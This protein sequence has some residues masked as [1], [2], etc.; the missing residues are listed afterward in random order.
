M[1]SYGLH[2]SLIIQLGAAGGLAG[3]RRLAPGNYSGP[4]GNREATPENP[5]TLQEA[6]PYREAGEGGRSPDPPLVAREQLAPD[7]PAMQQDVTSSAA[8]Q[9]GPAVVVST[10]P[11]FSGPG[12]MNGSVAGRPGP[13]S[14]P[15]VFLADGKQTPIPQ[16]QTPL[17]T[18]GDPGTFGN[19]PTTANRRPRVSTVNPFE[20]PAGGGPYADVPIQGTSPG[21]GGGPTSALADQE[22]P[23][24]IVETS[25]RPGEML[26]AL[27]TGELM[28]APGSRA[29]GAVSVRG[30]PGGGIDL[31]V[32]LRDAPPGSYAV[33]LGE[34]QHCA[35]IGAGGGRQ[36]SA[37]ESVG[38]LGT[39]EV[40][41]GGSGTLTT[42]IPRRPDEAA[43]GTVVVVDQRT[44]RPI[45]CGVTR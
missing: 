9:T 38:V 33:V 22:T 24:P 44:G 32:T 41:A 39:I 11:D 36:G 16:Q 4:Q 21:T 29:S 1:R 17:G 15:G 40:G 26:S 30:D 20:W 34:S 3:C 8:G 27:A 35:G 37:G 19:V 42:N 28:P 12:G 23:A 18:T 13:K 31:D 14:S 45:V 43:L 10:P 25:P 6:R 2:L 5:A 7:V